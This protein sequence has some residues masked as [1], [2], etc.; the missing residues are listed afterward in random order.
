MFALTIDQ[1]RSR[2]ARDLV[3]Q[4]L[5]ALAGLPAVLPFERTVGDE[6]Q[7]LLD[8]PDVVLRS[9]LIVLRQGGWH[10]GVGIGAIDVPLPTT[11][12]AARGQVLFDAREAVER[13]KR[14]RPVGL[15]VH[16]TADP[17]GAA[18][19]E[20]LLGLIGILIRRRTPTQWAVLDAVDAAPTQRA[21]AEALGVSPQNVSQ[22]LTASAIDIERAGYPGLV[23]ILERM[24]RA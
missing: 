1:R 10:A 20:A 12:R 3:P 22:T 24:E 13:S 5:D 15:C 21:A 4:L 23:R 7:G 11:V 2:S 6:I 18:D 17:V 9:L 16:S 8:D 19:A 14:A